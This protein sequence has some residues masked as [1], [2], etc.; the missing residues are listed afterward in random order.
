MSKSEGDFAMN[1]KIFGLVVLMLAVMASAVSA[2]PTI[3]RVDIDD[4][5][6]FEDQ[7][8]RLD[9]EVD[10]T[11]SVEI[12]ITSD[13]DYDRVQI[14]AEIT[15]YEHG[16]ISDRTNNFDT[17]ANALYKETLTLSLPADLD[18]SRIFLGRP[19][20]FVIDRSGVCLRRSQRSS[21]N[22]GR[23]KSTISTDWTNARS[24]NSWAISLLT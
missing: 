21:E 7:T 6:V 20:L 4:T 1:G 3:D 18:P 8:N 23:V 11:V 22:T 17:E 14:E 2:L 16:D 12:W 5:T 9:I 19:C 15:G 24:I 10:S 13:A